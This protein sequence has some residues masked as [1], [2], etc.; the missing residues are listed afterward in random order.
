MRSLLLGKCFGYIL[1]DDLSDL[2]SH[3]F[4]VVAYSQDQLI[5]KKKYCNTLDSSICGD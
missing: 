3:K 2:G 1:D 4:G 5:G